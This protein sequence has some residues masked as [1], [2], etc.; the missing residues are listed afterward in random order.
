MPWRQEPLLVPSVLRCKSET[1]SKRQ[2]FDMPWWWYWTVIKF[3]YHHIDGLVQDCSNSTVDA[4]EL[5]WSCTKPSIKW[6]VYDKQIRSVTFQS[7]RWFMMAWR[8]FLIKFLFLFLAKLTW[9][10][11]LRFMYIFC[12]S[13]KQYHV[14]NFRCQDTFDHLKMRPSWCIYNRPCCRPFTNVLN[15]S[16]ETK[17]Y[18][19]IL[20][21][22]ST[23]TWH[24]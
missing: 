17:T 12:T 22:S 10:K 5:L 6:R 24:G 14:S 7:V 23:L 16:Q 21:Y 15:F 18:I 1:N 8:F 9:N 4:L 2:G 19:Y 13:H 11:G 3:R 20:C